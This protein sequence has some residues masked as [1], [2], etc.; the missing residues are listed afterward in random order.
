M[1]REERKIPEHDLHAYVDGALDGPARAAVEA[2]LADN[3]AIAGEVES[4]KRQNET[5]RALYGHGAA[6]PVPPRL[7]V[8]RLE[9]ESRIATTRWS[10]M[11]P[12]AVLL[13]G[14]GTVAGWYGRDLLASAGPV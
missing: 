3:P 6:E 14:V 8:R 13:L 9:R 2:Y 10:R 1:S 7:D 4:W 12:A 5:L 11:A